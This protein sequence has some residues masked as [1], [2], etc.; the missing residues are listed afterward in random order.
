MDSVIPYLIYS[1]IQGHHLGSLPE[2]PSHVHAFSAVCPLVPFPRPPRP[3][4]WPFT[5]LQSGR[6]LRPQ[7]ACQ[8]PVHC[9]RIHLNGKIS[10]LFFHPRCSLAP[11]LFCS[12]Y[13][14]P[15]FSCCC[16]RKRGGWKA[17][18][19]V[20]SERFILPWLLDIGLKQKQKI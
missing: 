11:K 2:L 19:V 4:S 16:W 6:P 10:H 17:N 18:H 14:R 7:S 13:V 3:F 1:G 9:R 8:F 12:V 15:A 20:V 5:E